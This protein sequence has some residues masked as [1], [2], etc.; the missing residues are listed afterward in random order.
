MAQL[1]N[2][3]SDGNQVPS[4]QPVAG[5]DRLADLENAA[6]R[7]SANGAIEPEFDGEVRR[8]EPARSVEGGDGR[9]RTERSRAAARF[10][11]TS[12]RR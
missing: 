2:N 3:A 5:R 7:E 12:R 11:W 10:G 1:N 9:T 4:T 6:R 8:I